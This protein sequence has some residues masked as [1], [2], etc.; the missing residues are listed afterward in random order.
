[1]LSPDRVPSSGRIPQAAGR[2]LTMY[3]SLAPVPT[4]DEPRAWISEPP[5]GE[6]AAGPSRVVE[7]QSLRGI[8]ALIVLISHCS[9]V[10][11]MPEG[12]RVAIDAL[13]NPRAAVTFFFVLSGYVL[14]MALARRPATL[15]STAGF[16]VRR[17]F[18][19]VPLVMVV[20]LLALSVTA[21]LL[22]DI[23]LSSPWFKV[24]VGPQELTALQLVL[25]F[26]ALSPVL[27]P[28]TWTIFVEAI[29]SLFLPAHSWVGTRFR[30]GTA[31]IL[32]A[33]LAL[34]VAISFA[35]SLHSAR[36][37]VYFAA[38][39]FLY[40]HGHRWEAA[41]RLRPPV[42]MGLV[43][44]SALLLFGFRSLWFLAVDGRLAPLAVD[45]NNLWIGLMEGL[46][47]C[48]LLAGV[49]A[50]KDGIRGLSHRRVVQLGDLSFG[51]Y[52]LHFPV[53]SALAWGL[54]RA[55]GVGGGAPLAHTSLLL[56][57]TLAVV[58]PLSWLAYR[59][60]ELPGIAAGRAV[61]SLLAQG[62]AQARSSQ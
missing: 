46:F 21:P 3:R 9:L 57:L 22:V 40:T 12:P 38:G 55:F 51:I 8:M 1:M 13:V 23:P 53:M 44:L 18:R 6:P 14:Q 42:A 62:G 5:A 41:L 47:A 52:L 49:V 60:I 34:T 31:T 15:A 54:Y 24:T 36:F 19:L 37:L 25:A 30:F 58:L 33:L 4:V 48:T 35:G 29:G 61:S 17:V 20:S 39:A 32:G 43:W 27:V 10:Y 16:Y 2:P 28:T 45:Y 56:G 59:W 11:T 26:F 50:M 7:L